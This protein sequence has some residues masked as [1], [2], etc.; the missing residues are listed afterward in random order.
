[1]LLASNISSPSVTRKPCLSV[2]VVEQL[3]ILTHLKFTRLIMRTFNVMDCAAYFIIYFFFLFFFKVHNHSKCQAFLF[4]LH[5]WYEGRGYVGIKELFSNAATWAVNTAMHKDIR[6]NSNNV[7]ARQNKVF[8]LIC[9]VYF[10]VITTKF[11]SW[12]KHLAV[13]KHGNGGLVFYTAL[14]DIIT[15]SHVE[16]ASMGDQAKAP[17]GTK[18]WLHLSSTL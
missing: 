5:I 13:A 18:Y 12:C 9:Y 17:C 1:M 6:D 14:V 4:C 11:G 10:H 16:T 8:F 2:S 7:H 3:I 15:G